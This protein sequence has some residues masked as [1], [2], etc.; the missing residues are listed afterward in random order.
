MITP[1]NQRHVTW[2][3]AVEQGRRNRREAAT[4]EAR[5]GL[6]QQALSKGGLGG[7]QA[8]LESMEILRETHGFRSLSDGER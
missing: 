4:L 5:V 2:Q 1:L 8:G 6:K 7:A 3:E